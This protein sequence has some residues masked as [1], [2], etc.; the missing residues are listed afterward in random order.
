MCDFLL[1]PG[2]VKMN[3]NT[4]TNNLL[5]IN[6]H[7]HTLSRLIFLQERSIDWSYTDI[8]LLK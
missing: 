6:E 1:I 4:L 8:K 2:L 5:I 7:C 3:L